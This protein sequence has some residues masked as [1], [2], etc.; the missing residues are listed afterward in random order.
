MSHFTVA[1]FSDGTKTV[2]ELLSLYNE[3]IEV[4]PYISETKEQMIERAKERKAD[5]IERK[6]K[7]EETSDWMQQYIDAST[8]EELYQCEFD[9]DYQYDADGNQLSTYNPD[10]KWDWYSIGGRWNGMLKAKTGLHGGG[11]LF[12][13]NRREQGKYDSAK[14]SD[15]DFSPDEEIYKKSIRFWEVVVDKQELLPGEDKN[16]FFNYYK[17]SYYTSRY[18]DK[19]TYARLQ[20]SFSTFAVITPDGKW[21]E[22]GKMGWWA[23]VSNEEMAWDEKY[24]ERFIDTAN[25]DWTLTI[26]DCHI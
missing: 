21:Y 18:G 16:N 10:S 17:E 4:A 11:G 2:D 26:V 14:V 7:D 19:E 25:L 23:A 15:I 8:D 3:N 13:P 1:V 12:S 20:A 22:K 9:D 6:N 24:K 5:Y